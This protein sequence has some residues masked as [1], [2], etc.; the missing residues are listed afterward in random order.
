MNVAKLSIEPTERRGVRPIVGLA[1]EIVGFGVELDP[2]FLAGDLA[3]GEIVDVLD[4]AGQVGLF[5]IGQAAAFAQRR[6]DVVVAVVL[7]EAQQFGAV[8]LVRWLLCIEVSMLALRDFRE[9]SRIWSRVSRGLWPPGLIA[10][11]SSVQD[12]TS[13]ALL[14]T[15]PQHRLGKI[16]GGVE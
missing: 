12:R 2:V 16:G 9:C 3:G 8:E 15:T 10:A 13:A 4:H 6:G 14:A 11:R 1:A 7:D 5:G